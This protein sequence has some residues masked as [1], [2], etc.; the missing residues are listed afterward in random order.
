MTC[1]FHTFC[2]KALIIL[3]HCVTVICFSSILW[4]NSLPWC[5]LSG[6]AIVNGD[7]GAGVRA[8]AGAARGVGGAALWIVGKGGINK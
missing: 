7:A 6:N 5:C 3:Q 2:Y 4:T 1:T 8:F